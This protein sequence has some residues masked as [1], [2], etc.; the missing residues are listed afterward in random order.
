MLD[1]QA[2]RI[3]RSRSALDRVHP[4]YWTYSTELTAIERRI[5]EIVERMRGQ[6]ARR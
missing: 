5:V 2:D 4:D 6:V 3:V 1:A